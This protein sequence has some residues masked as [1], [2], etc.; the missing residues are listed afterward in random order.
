MNETTRTIAECEA[1]GMWAYDVEVRQRMGVKQDLLGFIDV[2]AGRLGSPVLLGIQTTSDKHRPNRVRKIL[3]ECRRQSIDWLGCGHRIEVW[4][5]FP[6]D[7]PSR[8]HGPL[9][10]DQITWEGLNLPG[11]CPVCGPECKCE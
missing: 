6:E 5:W 2:L 8:K 3:N 4:G 11:P 7:K 1:R 10:I 9:R